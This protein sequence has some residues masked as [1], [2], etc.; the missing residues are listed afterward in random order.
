MVEGFRRAG[1][2]GAWTAHRRDVRES[3]LDI[4]ARYTGLERVP[5]VVRSPFRED[6]HPSVS[7]YRRGKRVRWHDFATDD[8]GDVI[9]LV[10]RLNSIGYH[11]CVEMLLRDGG[12]GL[13]VRPLTPAA[14]RRHG[15]VTGLRV[16]TRAWA[17]DDEEWWG[18][19][20]VTVGFLDACDV[21]PATDAVLSHEDGSETSMRTDRLAYAYFE[22]KDGAESVKLYQPESR[23]MKWLSKADA[24]VWDLWR[25]A[26]AWRDRSR[27]IL[28]SSRKDA[29]CLW[30]NLGVPCM[31]LQ[32][33]GVLPKRHVME[34]V[35]SEFGEVWLWYDNDSKEGGGNPG[36]GFA[37]RLLRLYPGLRNIC[38]PDGLESK[39]PS[40]LYRDHG[41]DALRGVWDARRCG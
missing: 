19:F 36:Q 23:R 18:R 27:L 14:G 22:W 5:C 41:A 29:M 8:G 21:H 20:G 17:A 1:P 35:L 12:V 38:N 16:R 28:T 15:C 34:R 7:I 39:D 11:E 24:S 4:L 3:D 37:A 25:Q 40:D 31:S 26:H 30:Q 2:P 6:R 10:A 13:D 32:G 9:D 33:E